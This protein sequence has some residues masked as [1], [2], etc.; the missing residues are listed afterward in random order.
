MPQPLRPLLKNPLAPDSEVVV[1]AHRG[2]SGRWPENT[3]LAFRAAAELGVDGLELDIH[4]TADGELVV[5]HDAVVERVTNGRGAVHSFT[6]AELRLLDA[7]YWWT[8]DGGRSYP[9]RGQGITIPTLAEVFAAFPHLWLN[10][11]IKQ[12]EPPIVRPFVNLIRTYGMEQRVCVG[13]FHAP[14]VRAFRQL[15]PE[16]ATAATLPE[17]RCFWALSNVALARL[18]PA[19]AVAMQLPEVDGRL[20]LITPAFVRAAHRRGTAVHVWTVNDIPQMRRLVRMGVD[21]LMSDYPDLLLRLL[22]R[23]REWVKDRRQNGV[24]NP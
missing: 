7:G 1:F 2:G 9:F 24:R 12:Q 6:L 10:I 17:V 21:G 11:D 15:C 20:R 16:V 13:S 3:M 19:T 5:I 4:S 22:R 18:C 14:T 8:Q 23:G